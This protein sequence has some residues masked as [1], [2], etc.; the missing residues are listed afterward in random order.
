MN[1]KVAR[2]LREKALNL[3]RTSAYKDNITPRMFYKAA[4]K[5]YLSGQCR[6]EQK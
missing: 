3:W 1:G 6:F 5:D 4:K 2:K